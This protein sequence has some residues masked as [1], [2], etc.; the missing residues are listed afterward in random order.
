MLENLWSNLSTITSQYGWTI[1]YIAIIALLRLMG[2]PFGFSKTQGPETRRRE[3]VNKI[4][5]GREN[6]TSGPEGHQKTTRSEALKSIE[7]Q[8]SVSKKLLLPLLVIFILFFHSP[9][10]RRKYTCRRYFPD[11]RRFYGDLRHR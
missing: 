11:R 7:N 2:P 4:K 9:A 8:F 10:L 5:I 6:V 3:R 1:A